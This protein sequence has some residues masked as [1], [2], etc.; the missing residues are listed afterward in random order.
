MQL[1]ME[2]ELLSLPQVLQIVLVLK[3]YFILFYYYYFNFYFKLE[4]FTL[5][6]P[7]P[8]FLL[9]AHFIITPALM[10][11]LAMIFIF[12]VPPHHLMRQK[13]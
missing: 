12:R 11:E 10:V 4:L 3:V 2:L 8:Q 5:L 6:I 7:L 1:Q 13:Q 9:A